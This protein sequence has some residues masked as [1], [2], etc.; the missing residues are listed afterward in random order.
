MP[1]V[2]DEKNTYRALGWNWTP[3]QEPNYPSPAT[4]RNGTPFTVKD[5]DIHHDTEGDDLWTYLMMY[6]RTGQKGYLD[7]AK[8]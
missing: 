4:L 7:R 5:P 3:Y 1:T 2:E 8:E 6:L